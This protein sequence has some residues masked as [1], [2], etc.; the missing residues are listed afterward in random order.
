MKTSPWLLEDDGIVD[1]VAV[2][3]AAAG[4]RDVRLTETERRLAAAR[5]MADHGHLGIVCRRLHVSA[6]EAARLVRETSA[7]VATPA[8]AAGAA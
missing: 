6:S 4:L 7:G 5:I 8:E 3:V 1:E 2:A